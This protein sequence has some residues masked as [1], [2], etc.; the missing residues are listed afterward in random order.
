MNSN[1]ND[2]ELTISQVIAK[3]GLLRNSGMKL[4]GQNFLCNEDLLDRIVKAA[5]PID[6]DYDILEI[7]PG[8][9]GL[10]RS[11]LNL[12]SNRLFCI[13]KDIRFKSLHDNLLRYSNKNLH[14]IYDDAL[15]IDI[16]DLTKNKVV[17]IANLPYNVSTALLTKWLL[18]NIDQIDKMILM[19]QKEVAERIC[20]RV[21]TKQYGKLSILSQ[22]L[23]NVEQVFTISNRAFIP[24]P[25]VISAVVLFRP[26]HIT[27]DSIDNFNNLIEVC[28][29]HR[30]K[31]IRSV[32]GKHYHN[33]NI[34]Q[35]LSICNI[36]PIQRPESID[37]M[38]FLRITKLIYN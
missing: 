12:T 27:I 9:C 13:E 5:A 20:A 26:K 17:I 1:D 33:A 23:C 10:T 31:T 11:I 37:S 29:Q 21:N 4:F 34:D 2:L 16:K 14:F 28:F 22:L 30:R 35:I 6:S 15:N 24:V 19:F 25:K 38:Q 18:Y 32:L 7:G 3:Y 36:D 8:P